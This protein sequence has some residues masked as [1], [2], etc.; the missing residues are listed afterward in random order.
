MAR[1][2]QWRWPF[3]LLRWL[4]VALV[5]VLAAPLAVLLVGLLIYPLALV[6]GMAGFDSG[7][8]LVQRA[9]DGLASAFGP[10]ALPTWI[11]RAATLLSGASVAVLAAGAWWTWWRAPLHR[12]TAGGKALGRCSARRSMRRS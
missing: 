8:A 2:Y 10:A 11:P 5:A 3:R 6:L 9:L 12:R 7:A 4:G 1:F